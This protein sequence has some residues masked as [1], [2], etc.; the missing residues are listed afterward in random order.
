[1]SKKLGYIVL[2]GVVLLFLAIGSISAV[3][4][5]SQNTDFALDSS[6]SDVSISSTSSDVSGDSSFNDNQKSELSSE[7]GEV[8]ECA[9]QTNL[10]EANNLD[11]NIISQDE[12]GEIVSN[13]TEIKATNTVVTTTAG[14]SFTVTLTDIS[15]NSKLAGQV[16]K[17][18]VNGK[19]YNRT[20][21]S[22]G[23]ASLKITNFKPGVYPITFSYAGNEYYNSSS[24]SAK[25]TVNKI[26]TKIAAND[27]RQN[28]GDGN[29]YTIRLYSNLTSKIP[30][31]KVYFIIGGKT[32]TKIT[33]ANGRASIKINLKSGRHTIKIK[34]K[35]DDNHTAKTVTKTVVVYKNSTKLV[36]QRSIKTYVKGERFGLY[37]KDINNKV[38]AGKKIKITIGKTTYTRTTNANGLVSVPLNNMGTFNVNYKYVNTTNSFMSSSGKRKISVVKNSTS[39]VAL[40]RNVVHGAKCKY[41]IRLLNVYGQPMAGENISVTGNSHNYKLTTDN[42]GYVYINFTLTTGT[43]TIKYSY[44]NANPDLSSS[45][46]KTI[47]VVANRTY[48]SGSNMA[49]IGGVAKTYSVT[50][51]DQFKKALPNKVVT[52]TVDGKTYTVK[53]NDKG[54]ASQS[55]KLTS[56]TYTIKF[57]FAG[58]SQYPPVNNSKTLTVSSSANT[59][60]VYLFGVNMKRVNLK[61]LASYGVGN[62][63]LNYYAIEYWGKTDVLSF[64]SNAKSYGIKVHIWM[65]CF[66]NGKWV[67][68]STCGASY[69]NAVIKEA[70]TYAKMSG[71]AGIHLD[72]LRYPG[73]AYKYSGATNKITTFTKNLVNAVKAVD[74]NLMVSAAIMPETTVNAYYYGQDSSQLGKYLDV[75]MPMAYKGNYGQGTTW[76]KNTA[77]YFASHCGSAQVWLTLQTYKSDS[78]TRKLSASELKTDAQS[79]LNGGAHGV[80]FFRHEYT[81]YFKMSSLKFKSSSTNAVVGAVSPETSSE[82][83]TVSDIVN[84]AN[85]IKSYYA[86]N[87]KLPS[88]VQIS[89]KTVTMSEYLY[90]ASLAIVNI[91]NKD[92]SSIEALTDSVTEPGSPNSGDTL[93]KAKFNQDYY[94]DSASRTYQYILNNAQGPNYSTLTSTSGNLKVSYNSLIEAFSSILS[95]YGTNGELPAYINIT[96]GDESKLPSL[97]SS[98]TGS[99]GSISTTPTTS[100]SYLTIA[101]IIDGSNTVKT[102]YAKNSKLPTTV[103]IG[104]LKC[105]MS[106]FLY[107]EC[108]AIVHL[109]NGKSTSYKI[110]LINKTLDEPSSPNLGD[111]IS[112]ELLYKSGYVDSANRTYKFILN[113]LQG[114]NYSTTTVGK[115]C[116]NELVEAFSR[117]LSYYG[118]N[119]ALPNY[120]TI[121]TVSSSSSSSNVANTSSINALALSLTK[122]ITSA[123]TKAVTLFNWVRDN[124]KY[125]YYYNSQQGAAK[126]LKLKSG[127]CCDQSNLYVALCRAVGITVRY[128]HGYCHFSDGWYGHVWTE[129]KIDGK[130][131]SADPISTRNTFGSINNWN[132]NTV[133][134]YNRYTNLPF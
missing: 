71:V 67:N 15:S 82:S 126:T 134:I 75:I 118:E 117:V 74:K 46:S 62:I 57:A 50:L 86:A 84:A 120:V 49:M 129:V 63:L 36:P 12:S 3:D 8:M 130:W 87:S 122:N 108:L 18:T 47:T 132:T 31:K 20:T 32:Y 42:N 111:E 100:S 43:H 58:D 28:Y 103:T 115:V 37:L 124:V 131:Y 6:S 107:Y 24:G 91:Q 112:S 19:T 76:L 35:G 45:G 96:S 127:N 69:T 78:N 93:S 83:F 125:S 29:Y 77:K 25:L 114:P 72:Y 89:T 1:M 81:N 27:F 109:N 39:L 2:I 99:N 88:T 54:V 80:T 68:P 98:T 133:T 4:A 90:Y 13:A 79:A 102:Y 94:V 51:M 97:G 116:Y 104:S 70:V 110:S 9:T 17:F 55:L 121:K 22:K 123:Y 41:S 105:T 101:Q 128:V 23:V 92:K 119:N 26:T 30:N 106:Q 7:N 34:F 61:T 56:G 52:I 48:I 60:A 5:D 16:I 38:I 53:T 11:G 64:I 14:E 85:K 21:N 59:F 40:N 65:Q 44:K 95:Y 73:T 33:N 10:N 66:Y 113:Y